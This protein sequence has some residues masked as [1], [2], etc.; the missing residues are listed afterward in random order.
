MTETYEC[1][2]CGKSFIGEDGKNPA[3]QKHG[4]EIHC[5]SNPRARSKIAKEDRTERIPF[6]TPLRTF[7]VPDDDGYQYRI[8]NDNW[9]KEPGRIMRAKQAGYEVVPDKE[10]YSVGTNEDGSEIKGILM[11]LPK[12]LFDQDQALKQK[13]V[14]KV[15]DAIMK[16]TLESRPGDHRYSP[17]GITIS[18]DSKEPQ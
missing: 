17:A 8:F 15:D 1:Q 4:H 14:D 7:D 6:G 9:R 18:S 13:E 11:R 16:G 12:E 5:S 10:P 3:N 2:Y